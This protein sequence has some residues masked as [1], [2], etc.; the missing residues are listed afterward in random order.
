[1]KFKNDLSFIGILIEAAINYYEIL[2]MAKI[3]N[4]TKNDHKTLNIDIDDMR[5]NYKEYIMNILSFLK[6]LIPKKQ[7]DILLKELSFFDLDTSPI[8]RYSM[9]NSL[10]S[11]IDNGKFKIIDFKALL[12]NNPNFLELY[13]PIFE[14]MNLSIIS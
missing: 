9:D 6:Q 5:D 14:L 3:Y 13:K 8:Y 12:Y 1:M 10:I 2:R 4:E 7:R 11:H